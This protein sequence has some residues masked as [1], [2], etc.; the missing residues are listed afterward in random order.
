MGG[1]FRDFCI[2]SLE[3]ACLTLYLVWMSFNE[4]IDQANSVSKTHHSFYISYYILLV[5][6]SPTI[7]IGY[8]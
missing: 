7:D 3:Q 2:K 6:A 4:A 8:R 5:L 1:E